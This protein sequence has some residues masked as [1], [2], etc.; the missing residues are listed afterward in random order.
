MK[1]IPNLFT[2]FRIFGS[3]I[4]LFLKPSA[5]PFFC[6]YFLCGLSDMADGFIARKTKAV[7]QAGAMLD[8]LADALLA[9]VMMYI[10]IPL[11]QLPLWAFCYIF[12]ILIIRAIALLAGFIKYRKLV[13]LHT[14]ANKA[15]GLLL[16]CFPVFL[17]LFGTGATTVFLCTVAAAAAAEEALLIFTSKTLDRNVKSIFERS[18]GS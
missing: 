17:K 13:F 18:P 7:T 5:L 12:A 2:G 14:W 1:Y 6:V 4:L 9:G 3:L 10:F 11:L 15:A 16:F 8:S